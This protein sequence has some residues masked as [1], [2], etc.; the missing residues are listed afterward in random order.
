[1]ST[2]ESKPASD[3]DSREMFG[4]VRSQDV[5]CASA[6]DVS[7]SDQPRPT[8]AKAALLTMSEAATTEAIR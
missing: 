7:Q 2:A 3:I 1:M 6:Y 8:W 5:R 4:S